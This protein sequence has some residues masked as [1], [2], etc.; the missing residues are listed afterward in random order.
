MARVMQEWD[1]IPEFSFVMGN[2]PD[3]EGDI[4]QTIEFIRKIK[5]INPQSEIIMYL[6]TPVPLAGDLYENAKTAG[7]AFPQTGLM[8]KNFIQPP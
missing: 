7:F 5:R 4:R 6:Y 8:K 2:P 3:P 1:I